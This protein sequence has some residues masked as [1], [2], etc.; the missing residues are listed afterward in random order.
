MIRYKPAS[1]VVAVR[2]PSMRAGLLASTV[3]PGSTAP[4]VSLTTPA[5]ALCASAAVGASSTNANADA[6][7]IFLPARLMWPPTE[8]A[9]R[10]EVFGIGDLGLTQARHQTLNPE[11]RIPT[12]RQL[13]AR[14]Y[15]LL[16][17]VS[18]RKE[19]LKFEA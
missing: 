12:R 10:V 14:V 1:S 3:T 9:R 5:I 18:S 4:V 7:R 15:A 17:W 13:M 16:R 19:G 2:A 8:N 11:S 6:N